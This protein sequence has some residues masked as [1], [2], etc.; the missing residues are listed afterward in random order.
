M[1]VSKHRKDH[2]KKSRQRTEQIKIA[3]RKQKEYML[4]QYLEFQRQL[5]EKQELANTQKSGEIIEN[6]E[7]DVDLDIDLN[8]DELL[9]NED[10]S[11]TEEE[12]KE[13]E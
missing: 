2:K 11:I 6:T 8:D 10:F 4:K 9:V 12:T 5:V 7:I 13:E 1:G 3:Q